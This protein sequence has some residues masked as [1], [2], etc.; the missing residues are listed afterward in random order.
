MCKGV[1]QTCTTASMHF[2]S[3]LIIL[4]SITRIS[5]LSPWLQPDISCFLLATRRA[6]NCNVNRRRSV[7]RL[8]NNQAIGKGG[9]VG[10]L[11]GRS[12]T[13]P[14][15]DRL[16]AFPVTGSAYL[17]QSCISDWR[18]NPICAVRRPLKKRAIG[19]NGY[20]K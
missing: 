6:K 12:P 11:V 9:N 18:V 1:S 4:P 3:A 10:G 19:K 16:F 5:R 2:F 14:V 17:L 13:A 15:S 20:E 8:S 7:R